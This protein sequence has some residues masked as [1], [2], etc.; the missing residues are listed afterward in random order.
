MK[1][2]KDD[3]EMTPHISR[4]LAEHAE[5]TGDPRQL[6]DW[7]IRAQTCLVFAAAERLVKES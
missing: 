5:L 1:E 3:F 7:N 6:K 2:Q 4:L